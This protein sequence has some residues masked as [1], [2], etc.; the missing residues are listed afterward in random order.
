MPSFDSPSP[1]QSFFKNLEM[2]FFIQIQNAMRELLDP[3]QN[4][5]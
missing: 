3:T 5:L 2:I 1:A 4:S